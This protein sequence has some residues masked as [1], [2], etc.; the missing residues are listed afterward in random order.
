M[1]YP[2]GKTVDLFW[3]IL[4]NT[5]GCLVEEDSTAVKCHIAPVA[6]CLSTC[7]VLW[8]QCF[9]LHK[10][11]CTFTCPTVLNLS[12]WRCRAIPDEGMRR[13]FFDEYVAHLQ[14]KIKEKERKREKEDKVFYCH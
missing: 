7:Y 11:S 2:N 9:Y 4:R 6:I 14:Q 8:Y 12:C 1:L 3:K 5:G 10:R 13:N